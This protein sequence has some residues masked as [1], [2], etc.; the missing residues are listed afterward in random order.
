MRASG[1]VVGELLQVNDNE[2]IPRQKLI[3]VVHKYTGLFQRSVNNFN[4]MF[5]DNRS[6]M[7]LR[8]DASHPDQ[9]FERLKPLL[10]ARLS[11]LE[12]VLPQYKQGMPMAFVASLMGSDPVDGWYAIRQNR[13]PV[14]VCLGTEPERAQAFAHLRSC[15]GLILDPI[16]AWVAGVIGVLGQLERTFGP[17]GLAASTVELFEERRREASGKISRGQAVM[18]ER[19]GQVILVQAT[20]AEKQPI[21]DITCKMARWSRDCAVIIP[22][23]S[24]VDFSPE[25]RGVG[26]LIHRTMSD[27]IAAASGSGRLFLCEDRHLRGWGERVASLAGVWLQPALMVCLER[28]CLSRSVYDEA[29]TK[30]ALLGH[31]V[32][33]LDAQLLLR[34][35][36][37]KGWE[38]NSAYA[39]LVSILASPTIEVLSLVRLSAT[40]VY[41]LWSLPKSRRSKEALTSILLFACQESSQ[42]APVMVARVLEQVAAAKPISN[43]QIKRLKQAKK[44]IEGW[45]RLRVLRHEL[46]Q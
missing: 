6:M 20:E 22:A 8:F 21:E 37:A 26:D 2:L 28:N 30:L 3:S 35:A 31:S 19:D 24:A 42:D 4:S 13:L 23:I 5:P 44:F 12:A 14:D 45:L 25:I 15:T 36:D 39:Q 27:T 18:A 43:E 9:V 11:S 17:L 1:L 32:I 33:A 41:K 10:S 7:S 29:V 16:T 40:F 34:A 38:P 46:S